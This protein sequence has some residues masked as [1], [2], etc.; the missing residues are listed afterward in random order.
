MS[1][2]LVHTPSSADTDARHVGQGAY[3][4]RLQIVRPNTRWDQVAAALSTLLQLSLELLPLQQLLLHLQLRQPSPAIAASYVLPWRPAVASPRLPPA[5]QSEAVV[6]VAG[7]P[8]KA[9]GQ[10]VAQCNQAADHGLT[11]SR[12]C[13]MRSAAC[14]AALTSA[15]CCCCCCCCR[16]KSAR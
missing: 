3:C 9:G 1:R 14:A 5:V 2:L 10:Q 15:S 7:K 12:S 4:L 11:C 6:L 16:C 8:Q 13:A